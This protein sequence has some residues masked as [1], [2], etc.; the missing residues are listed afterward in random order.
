MLLTGDAEVMYQGGLQRCAAGV[1]GSAVLHA[2]F[3]LLGILPRVWV[4]T[5]QAIVGSF[6]LMYLRYDS[7]TCKVAVRLPVR[8]IRLL[9][10]SNTHD[11]PSVHLKRAQ[12]AG[13]A[14]CLKLAR[15]HSNAVDFTKCGRPVEFGRELR[16]NSYPDFMMKKNKECHESGTIIGRLFREI[17]VPKPPL[18]SD[19]AS[20]TVLSN[21]TSQTWPW[22][23][24]LLQFA[25]PAA[26]C[27]LIG[28]PHRH[29]P[30]KPVSFNNTCLLSPRKG[31]GWW[32]MHKEVQIAGSLWTNVLVCAVQSLYLEGPDQDLVVDGYLDHIHE[33]RV[34][35][36]C[37]PAYYSPS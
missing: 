7:V 27:A 13:S 33:A 12:G 19:I 24:Y 25:K 2:R 4:L 36:S 15:L 14:K 34:R 8:I 11:S 16:A 26:P 35:C 37:T 5:V 29:L 21:S 6:H 22:Y 17:E 28:R 31:P 3:L 23:A 9:L 30:G 1:Q 18:L 10:L 32:L 20:E